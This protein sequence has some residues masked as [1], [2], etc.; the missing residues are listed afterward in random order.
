MKYE[1]GDYVYMFSVTDRFVYGYVS[2]VN[3]D[4]SFH[5]QVGKLVY[6]NL[7]GNHVCLMYRKDMKEVNVE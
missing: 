2:F 5:V 6:Q 4:N 3:R 1:L 7:T